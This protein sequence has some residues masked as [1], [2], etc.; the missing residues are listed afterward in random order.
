VRKKALQKDTD[1]PYTQGLLF[2]VAIQNASL[3]FGIDGARN[4]NAL[5]IFSKRD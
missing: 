1:K 3:E 4:P 5:S 2:L